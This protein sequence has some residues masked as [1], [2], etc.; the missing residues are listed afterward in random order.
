MSKSYTL[1]EIL[2]VIGILAI[3]T[4]LASLSIVS[5]GKSS[6][7]DTSKTI[8][9]GA[10]KEARAQS[11]AVVDDKS[12]GVHLETN[13]A[14]IYADSGSGYSPSDQANYSKVL[15]TNTTLTWILTGGGAEVLFE[16]RTGKTQN[17]GTIT[18]S[19]SA[20][21]SREIIINSEGMIE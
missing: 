17:S 2:I 15:E 16:K 6:D 21:V 7:I 11:M 3:L 20:A 10:F 13:K 18:L 1:I 12:W 9:V 19:G 8:V 4:G 5:F 14:V